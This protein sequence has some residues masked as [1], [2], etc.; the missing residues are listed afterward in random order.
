[1]PKKSKK[2]ETQES[3]F[4]QL[5]SILA[6]IRETVIVADP[7]GK[8]I[9][10]NPA[11]EIVTGLPSQDILGHNLREVINFDC[12]K[13]DVAWFFPEALQGCRAVKLPEGCSAVRPTGDPLP[14][15]ATTTPF[16]SAD[17]EYVG[18]VLN[19]RDLTEE[20]KA[21]KRQYEFL[22][23]VSHQLRQPFSSL[24]LGL[25]SLLSQKKPLVEHDREVISDLHGV[26]L[27]FIDFINDLIKVSR[28]EEGRI[29]I[30]KE[31]VDVK[32]IAMGVIGDLKDIAISK[33]VDVLPFPGAKKEESFIINSD[34]ERLRDVLSN[35]IANA[36]LYNRPRGD[37]TIEAKIISS[38]EMEET[39]L[40]TRGGIDVVQ[41][42]RLVTEEKF[43]YATPSPT[44][45][46]DANLPAQAGA[47]AGKKEIGDKFL[48]ITV[49]DSG[50]GIPSYEQSR[51]F[52]TFYRGRNVVRKGLKGT[53]LGLSIVRAR[54]ERLGG[55]ITFE[56]QED[57]GSA[58][59]LVFP[60]GNTK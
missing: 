26:V 1:M 57:V 37:V 39:I 44:A 48:L 5:E 31:D 28:L 22:S 12:T 6:S 7:D 27:R 50:M 34:R 30:K 25:E 51:V 36:I 21:K 54:V 32:E 58:F 23:F 17:G 33:N 59:Y 29:E 14:I 19:I 4:T 52:E 35:L 42:I 49:S 2:E 20:F 53:G 18:I 38:K 16:F 56:S 55:W 3:K 45:S 47:L 46:A 10:A 11:S 13:T 8:I 15:A 24:R 40:K 9:L 43:A 60:A 41:R